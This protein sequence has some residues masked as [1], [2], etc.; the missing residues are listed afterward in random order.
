LV[1]ICRELIT[2]QYTRRNA[3][4][5]LIQQAETILEP[6]ILTIAFARRFATYKRADLLLQDPNR[7]EAIIN[8][9]QYPVQFIFAGKAHPKDNEGKELIKRVVE[10][11]RRPGVCRRIAFIENYDMRIARCLLQGA[12]VWLNTPR[13]P[14]EAC[15]TSGMKAAINGTLNVSIMDGWWAEGYSDA[16]GWRIGNGEE[17]TDRGY[18]DAVES[19]ALYNVLENEVIPCFYEHE[20]GDMPV[21][22]VAMMKASMKLALGKYSSLR[23]MNEYEQRFYLPAMEQYEQLL[24]NNAQVAR[25]LSRQHERLK[26][27]W[28]AIQIQ[29]PLTDA[30]GPHLVDQTFQI[31]AHVF[32]GELTPDEVDVELFFGNLKTLETIAH[33]ST[34]TMT[35]E[36][37]QG[38]GNFLYSGMLPCYAAGRFGFTVRATPKG[39]D[40]IKNTP[41]LITWAQTG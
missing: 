15:G 7:L 9:D 25:K 1:R 37:E 16:C 38:N 30:E 2:S 8:S 34:E 18:Q 21:H 36:M 20:N 17:Y 27:H 40:W 6:N 28:H 14:F 23:M 13:R 24:E 19:R 35:V 31:T 22:W 33:G 3:P 29:K 32:L 11:A 4:K 10:F 41:G 39:D 5:N 12:D 26:T